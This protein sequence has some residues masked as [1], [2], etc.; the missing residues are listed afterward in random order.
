MIQKI[1]CYEHTKFQLCIKVIFFSQLA[2]AAILN[3]IDPCRCTSNESG[4]T[5][6]GQ[7][8]YFAN[9]TFKHINKFSAQWATDCV[10]NVFSCGRGARRVFFILVLTQVPPSLWLSITAVF[11]PSSAARRAPA[12][13]PEPP[14]ITR[15]SKRV[16]SGSE[17]MVVLPLRRIRAPC[18]RRREEK[19]RFGTVN[20]L[21]GAFVRVSWVMS[22]AITRKL[23]AQT[24]GVGMG[25][26]SDSRP[27]L[28]HCESQQ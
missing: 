16:V 13:P 1:F 5:S 4:S 15:K 17:A 18:L 26:S 24:D 20:Q 8:D 28:C 2:V 23:L 6:S 27:L 14:P 21:V 12:R 7:G 19:C 25:G 10:H 9:T 3:R 22:V 11:A